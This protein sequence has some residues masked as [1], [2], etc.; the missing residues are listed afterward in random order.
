MS[1]A[2]E[3]ATPPVPHAA[4]SSGRRAIR[5][6]AS[7]RL[8]ARPSP[9][10][11]A[12][13]RANVELGKRLV[14]CRVDRENAIEAGDLEDFVMFRSEQTSQS[15][16]SFVRSGLTPPTRTPSVVE[17]MNVAFVKSTTTFLLPLPMTSSSCCLK[18][19]AV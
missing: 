3:L 16:P 14:A 9:P 17:S 18:S 11:S 1:D 6:A 8:K 12:G 2:P 7:G 5:Q 13:R 4:A 15:W 10:T 19:G